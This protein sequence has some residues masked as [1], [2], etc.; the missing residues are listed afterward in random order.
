MNCSP[1]WCKET[2]KAGIR[3]FNSRYDF[4]VGALNI[5]FSSRIHCVAL[6]K[7]RGSSL[8]EP[9]APFLSR[10]APLSWRCEAKLSKYELPL[11]VAVRRDT[12]TA[13]RQRQLRAGKSAP[14]C[15]PFLP[16][17]VPLVPRPGLLRLTG[18]RPPGKMKHSAPGSSYGAWVSSAPSRTFWSPQA[19]ADQ[20]ESPAL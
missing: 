8:Q 9:R 17:L 11:P 1:R 7:L 2:F 20:V 19:N 6:P 3:G 12:R 5:N 15:S 13:R 4:C 14:S 16:S 10:F 18:L